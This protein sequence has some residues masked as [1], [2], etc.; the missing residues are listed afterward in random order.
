MNM[1][2]MGIVCADSNRHGLGMDD[3]D[4]RNPSRGLQYGR[5]VQRYANQW[6]TVLCFSRAC[7]ARLGTVRCVDH[8]LE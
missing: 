3:S 6:R 5:A 4:D 7:T 1:I 8:G 2:F